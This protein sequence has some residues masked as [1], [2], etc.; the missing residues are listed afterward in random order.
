MT[1]D[2]TSITLTSAPKQYTHDQDKVVEPTATVAKAMAR[3]E[4]LGEEGAAPTIAV[5]AVPIAGAYSFGAS[6]AA[7]ATSGKGL[8]PAQAQ[9]S[10]VME[11]CER[12]S[13]LHFDYASRPDYRFT[14][15]EALLQRGVRTVVPSYFLNNF[16]DLS[17]KDAILAEIVRTPL[18]WVAGT[19]LDD[20]QPFY[21]P[22]N[23]HNLVFS[24]NGLA[25]GNS[26]EEAIL[27]GL[28]E[29]I[30][31]E[32]IY[33][34]LML[35]EA[36]FDVDPDSLQHPL[37][38]TVRDN[39][40]AGGIDFKIK[41]V[42]GE[43]SVPTFI[44]RG[45]KQADAG[46]LTYE[47]VGQGCHTDPQKALMRAFSE[48]FEGL[49]SM[50]QLQRALGPELRG[51]CEILPTQN[52]GFLVRH[53]AAMLDRSLGRQRLDEIPS[54]SRPDIKEEIDIVSAALHA[55]ACDVV[56]IDKTHPRLDIPV[57]RVFV[58]QFRSCMGTDTASPSQTLSAVH[59]EAG[60]V[61]DSERHWLKARETL[62][63]LQVLRKV[64]VLGTFLG[65]IVQSQLGRPAFGN[66]YLDSMRQIAKAKNNGLA[67]LA[68]TPNIEAALPL[69]LKWIKPTQPEA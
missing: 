10:A 12:Y 63:I 37:L 14:S 3:L 44:V 11:F 17:G 23:W 32:N 66:D 8:T 15:Y 64:P 39:A 60:N 51:L 6:T 24:S 31:R 58:P 68:Q 46:L 33:R 54:L 27:Q 18:K 4:Q 59:H 52:L 53:N 29:V 69:L 9:A 62:P 42:T 48:Y 40:A 34:L 41:N 55:R 30:E 47:G 38:T 36:G 5:R 25:S 45:R 28:C 35:G 1:L 13:W 43:L 50:N 19:R 65:P 49:H 67:Q 61:A 57:V 26:L 22:L 21:Y 20:S 16:A 7:L 2:R 56:V